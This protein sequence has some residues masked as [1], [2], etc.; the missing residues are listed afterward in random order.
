MAVTVFKMSQ[1][2]MTMLEGIIVGWFKKEGDKVLQDEPLLEV[3]TDK[4]VIEVTAPTTG[5]I[6]KIL[7]NV[8]DTVPV[9]GDL[10]IIADVDENISQYLKDPNVDNRNDKR[11]TIEKESAINKMSTEVDRRKKISPLAKKISLAENIDY[12]SI[13]GT[14]PNGLIVKADIEKALNERLAGKNKLLGIQQD[15]QNDM[16]IEIMPFNGIRKVTA[17]RMMMSK[18]QTA[19]VTTITEVD[20]TKIGEDIKSRHV[21]YTT[22]IVKAVAEALKEFKIMNSS[23]VGNEIHI[24]KQI[25]INIA[26]ATDQSLLTPVIRNAGNKNL[27]SIGKDIDSLAQRAKEDKL[28][29]EDFSSG[30][31]TITNSGVFGSLMFTPIINYPQCAILGI[32]KLL[33]TPVVR[34]DEIV[35]ATMM[36][37]C[38]SYDH[39]IVD[40]EPA[41]KFLQKVKYYLENPEEL[42]RRVKIKRE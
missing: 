14:G 41:V 27:L 19:S 15:T 6:R 40:G 5:Y 26:I 38:L 42:I 2:S 33:K 8:G 39:R 25:N 12:T 29:L 17:D 16:D 32:G 21:S 28:T 34:N 18:Q 13:K 3:Q 35:I 37:L 23:I 11:E 31:F 22:Y 9:G 36:Y 30:T 1:I 7:A 20:M 4:V 24:K 10:C